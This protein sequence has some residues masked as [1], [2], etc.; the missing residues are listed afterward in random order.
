MT[1][2][3]GIDGQHFPG[4]RVF[5]FKLHISGLLELIVGLHL[6]KKLFLRLTFTLGWKEACARGV[7]G[8]D[9]SA[10]CFPTTGFLVFGNEADSGRVSP[11]DL[12]SEQG[13]APTGSLCLSRSCPCFAATAGSWHPVRFLR[14]PSAEREAVVSVRAPPKAGEF[15]V[16]WF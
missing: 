12:C 15:L 5:I 7:L 10:V 6:Q 9:P 1:L 16:L 11:A 14:T 8:E 4:S 3:H 13:R 2:R